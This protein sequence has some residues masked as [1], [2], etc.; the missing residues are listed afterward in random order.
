MS[1]ISD[2]LL[3]KTHVCATVVLMW[4]SL[5][6]EFKGRPHLYAIDIWHHMMQK[7]AETNDNMHTHLDEMCLMH[8]QLAGMGAS[9]THKDYTTILIVSLPKTYASHINTPSDAATSLGSPLTLN[10]IIMAVLQKY[11]QDVT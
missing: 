2:S 4:K 3:M 9:P 6:K 1:L 11:G 10:Q 5:C 7:R 8:E